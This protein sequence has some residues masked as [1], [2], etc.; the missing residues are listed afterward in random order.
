MDKLQCPGGTSYDGLSGEASPSRGISFRF[1]VYE[2]VGISVVEV[3]TRVG[4]SV[5]WVC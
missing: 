4:R 2:M 3:Y 5:V 1:Q